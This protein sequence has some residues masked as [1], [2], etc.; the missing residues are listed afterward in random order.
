MFYRAKHAASITK[1]GGIHSLRHAFA[2]HLLESG[3][4]VHTIQRLLGHSQLSTT[5]HY[6]HLQQQRLTSTSS[7]LGLLPNVAPLQQ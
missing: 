2:T 6:L 1:Q 7:L 5:A 3:V 4:D